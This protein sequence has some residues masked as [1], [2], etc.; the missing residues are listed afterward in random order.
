[1]ALEVTNKGSS[2]GAMTVTGFPFATTQTAASV[3]RAVSTSNIT[4]TNPISLYGTVSTLLSVVKQNAGAQSNV[5]DTDCS[6]GISVLGT[7]VYLI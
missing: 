7:I 1:M 6:T 2:T 3:S 4:L 5:L